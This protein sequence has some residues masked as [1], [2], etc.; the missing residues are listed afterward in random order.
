MHS[1]LALRKQ[2]EKKGKVTHPM[3]TCMHAYL[4]VVVIIGVLDTAEG[5]GRDILR[6][7]TEKKLA[8]TVRKLYVG[9]DYSRSMC[10]LLISSL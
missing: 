4:S 1:T 9:T 8:E 6:A 3:I 7:K 2:K 10:S 5:S